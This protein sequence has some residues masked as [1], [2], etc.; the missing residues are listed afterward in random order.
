MKK[1]KEGI[2]EI[3]KK[4]GMDKLFLILVAGIVLIVLSIPTSK[5][6]TSQKETTS[7]LQIQSENN[8]VEVLEL[9]LEKALSR[10]EGVGEVDVIITIK[11]SGEKIV[12]KNKSSNLSTVEE[13]DSNGGKR[14][15]SEENIQEDSVLLDG[16]ELF[17]VK[18][19]A[20]EIEGVVVIAEGGDSPSVVSQINDALYAL[21]DVPT[22]K[23]KV[24][25]RKS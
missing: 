17:V 12:D 20:P 19:I 21:F 11:D 16:G 18:E 15:S 9:K 6:D 24:L 10:M 13:E 2:K 7:S 3:I 5:E 1:D 4:I 23:I 22:H 8:Y 14:F 25:K